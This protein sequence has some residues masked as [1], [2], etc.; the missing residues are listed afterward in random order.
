MR[1]FSYPT[2]PPDSL[3]SQ[4]SSAIQQLF[5]KSSQSTFAKRHSIIDYFQLGLT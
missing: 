3:I 4:R 5:S 2:A 1:F